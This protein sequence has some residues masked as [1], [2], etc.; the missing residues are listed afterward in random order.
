MMRG[1]AHVQGLYNYPDDGKQLKNGCDVVWNIGLRVI[2]LYCTADYL[3]NYPKQSTWTG[4]PA[5][6]A[7]LAGT[8]EFSEQLGR[9]WNTV[10][11]TCFTFANGSTNWWRTNPSAAKMT[12]EYT[13][14]RALAEYLLTAYNGTGR[15]F[16]LQNWEGDWAFMD[17][18]V[19]NTY[20]PEYMVARYAAFLGV[21]QRAI[22]DARA[23][24][25]SDCQ[26]LMAVEVNRVVDARL[27][28]HRRR[29]M[30]DLAPRI[31]PD[32]I[33]FSAYDAT[34]VDQGS[35]GADIAA[36]KAATVPVFYKAL[37][38]IKV[39]FPK[40][41]LQI[42]EFGYPENEIPY[43]EDYIFDMITLTSQIAEQEG[44]DTFLFW[45][46]FDNEQGGGGPGTYRGYWLIKPDGSSTIAS[47][48]FTILGPGA[49]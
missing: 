37:K 42:G 16:I 47:R 18:F 15:R 35:W 19:A 28:P 24:V 44:A 27:Y 11:L 43:G 30:R 1:S 20:V 12:A 3:T 23:A 8:P 26:V 5:T 31:Q 4:S 41:I 9:H 17:A 29:I 13:E 38:A 33:S 46:A 10:V 14:M 7:E 34:I 45:Q 49:V 39:A 2:K 6:L 48:D 21:R 22:S 40:S 32:V 36:W 25:A